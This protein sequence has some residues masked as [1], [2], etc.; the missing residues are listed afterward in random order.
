MAWQT[1]QEQSRGLAGLHM[2]GGD[3][4]EASVQAMVSCARDGALSLY[5]GRVLM[6]RLRW[7]G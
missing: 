3:T 7:T 1:W 5:N 2:A 4:A 6:Y